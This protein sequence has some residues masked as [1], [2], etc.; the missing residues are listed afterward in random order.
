M[1]GMNKYLS[2]YGAC[3]L[4]CKAL[5]SGMWSYPKRTQE[6]KGYLLKDDA[7]EAS[8]LGLSVWGQM[9]VGCVYHLGD[10]K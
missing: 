7:V 1:V 3:R 10:R 2:E 6:S 5:D 4:Q 9:E 8:S